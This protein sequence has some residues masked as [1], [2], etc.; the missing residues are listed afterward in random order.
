M[1]PVSARLSSDGTCELVDLDGGTTVWPT[2]EAWAQAWLDEWRRDQHGPASEFIDGMTDDA[3]DGVV[4]VLAALA[5]RAAPVRN[6]LEWVG[7]GP[8]ED[9]LSHSGHG[10]AVLAEVER[11]AQRHPSF[12]DALGAVWLGSEVDAE[13]RSRLGALGAR[14]LTAP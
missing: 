3:V 7:A 12:Q 13:V 1:A 2:V 5:E 8:L 9:L 11:T 14:D 10:A 4:L 6:E